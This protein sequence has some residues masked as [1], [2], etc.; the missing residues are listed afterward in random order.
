MTELFMWEYEGKMEFGYK[1]EARFLT[2]TDP[3]LSKWRNEVTNLRPAKVVDEDAVVLDPA[4]FQRAQFALWET[5]EGRKQIIFPTETA[6]KIW[7]Q[8][9]PPTPPVTKTYLTTEQFIKV[10]K[11]LDDAKMKQLCVARSAD[12]S[13]ARFAA[14]SAAR[15]MEWR[16][17]HFAAWSVDWSADWSV[18]QSAALNAAWDAD[19][20]VLARD[21]ITD[22]HFEILTKP[23]T[24][25]GLSLFAE[26]WEEV[27]NPK[28]LE[29]KGFGAIVEAHT[30]K[31]SRQQWVRINENTWETASWAVGRKNRRKFVKLVGVAGATWFDETQQSYFVW[32]DLINPVVISEGQK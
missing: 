4:L 18:A 27:L 22:E 1:Y 7:K 25:C 26:D 19:L 16:V 32:S 17:R 12:Q 9:L 15:S 8:L 23:W 21:K 2:L 11:S 31:Y 6:D 20:A 24:S 10:Y 13:A 14:Q 3:Y 5:S 30:K 29:P 28:V